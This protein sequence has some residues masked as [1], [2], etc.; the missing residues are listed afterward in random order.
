[1]NL[2]CYNNCANTKPD[3]AQQSLLN[4]TVV[5]INH[6]ITELN[7]SNEVVTHW[8]SRLVHKRNR[9]S[10]THNYSLLASEGCH[11]SN[12]LRSHWADTLSDAIVKNS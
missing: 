10:W 4:D 9:N 7:T 1:M 11:L 8:T 5:K 12:R 2:G 6:L 3:P